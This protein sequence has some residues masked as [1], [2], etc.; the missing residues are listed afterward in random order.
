MNP[1]KM[2]G[3]YGKMMYILQDAISS[4]SIG[5]P[6][7]TVCLSLVLHAPLALFDF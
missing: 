1:E 4:Q 5:I 7:M 6:I 2:R 3:T